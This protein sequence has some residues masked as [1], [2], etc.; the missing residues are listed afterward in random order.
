[1]ETI[2]TIEYK[3]YT[4]NIHPDDHPLN[5]REDWEPL[6]TMICWH[7]RYNLGD[8]NPF[9]SSDEFFEFIKDNPGIVVLPLYLYD[10]SGISMSTGSFVGR[11]H[12]AEWDSGQ[13]GFIYAT[14]ED[15]Q[16]WFGWKYITKARREAVEKYLDG[17][18]ESYD[19]YLRGEVYGYTIEDPTGDELDE[20]CWGFFGDPHGYMFDDCKNIIDYDIQSR[21]NEEKKNRQSHWNKLKG[22]IQ[23][24][25]PFQYRQKYTP[26]YS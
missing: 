20:S 16:K 1:M 3:G 23:N 19:Q 21:I 8:E 4:I 14:R 12:H 6:G 10:H 22:Y 17:E 15:M 24:K 9:D 7:R 13:V 5:P 25:V 11:A 2:D 26:I 18:V